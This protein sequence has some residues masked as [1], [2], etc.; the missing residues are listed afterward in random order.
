M[1]YRSFKKKSFGEKTYY[2]TTFIIALPILIIIRPIQFLSNI[3]DKLENE[4]CNLR[5]RGYNKLF[6]RIKNDK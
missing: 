5:A 3:A 6:R 4:M 2:I 1:S